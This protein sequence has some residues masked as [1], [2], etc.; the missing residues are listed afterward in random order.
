MPWW[1]LFFIVLSGICTALPH[2]YA[3]FLARKYPNPGRRVPT[4]WLGFANLYLVTEILKEHAERGGR[5]ARL[6]YYMYCFGA[7]IPP[8]LIASLFIFDPARS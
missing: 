6:A 8:L 1:V 2:H 5:R 3:R 7:A 4:G